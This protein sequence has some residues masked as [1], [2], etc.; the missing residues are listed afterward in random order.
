MDLQDIVATLILPSIV[1]FAAGRWSYNRVAT[2]VGDKADN[3]LDA[4]AKEMIYHD[5]KKDEMKL[6]IEDYNRRLVWMGPARK[7]SMLKRYLEKYAK[8]KTVSPQA[9]ASLSYVFTTMNLSEVQAA[10]ILVSLCKD[11]GAEKISSV[12]KLLF[13][14][15]R[16]MKT[17]EGK[18][19]LQPIKTLIMSTYRDATVAETLIET[20]QQ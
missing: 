1:L 18:K 10:Q 4:F 7:E 16:V 20:S 19:A 11:M 8:R 15:S 5:G 13:L 2:R 14:G 12:G 9:I 17:P 3:T 6:C